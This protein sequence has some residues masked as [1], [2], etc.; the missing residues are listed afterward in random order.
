MINELIEIKEPE[1]YFSGVG[2]NKLP[3][4]SR[5]LFF[6]RTQ[7]ESLQQNDLKNRS[8]HRSLLCFNYETEGYV[9][10][11][12][13]SHSLKPGQALVILPYQFHHYSQLSSLKLKWL[14]CSFELEEKN[15]L[16]PLRNQ[17]ITPSEKS[18]TALD[19]LLTEWYSAPNPMRPAQVQCALLRLL[20]CLRQDGKTTP[21]PQHPVSG[22]SLIRTIN[23]HLEESQGQSIT[24]SDLARSTGYSDSRLRVLFK[25]AAGI[26]LGAYLQNYRINR[27]I[28]LLRTTNIPIADVAEAA[29]FGSPQAFS[30]IFKQTTD[31]S[32]RA[33]RSIATKAP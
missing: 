12:H 29:G 5:V 17:V 2:T 14:F 16:E 28:A 22:N 13:Y 25:E 20:L 3:M 32:P 4:P 9:H 26:P 10:L 8:H 15:F 30:R 19:S 11:D 7:K 33:Y 6:L 27:A 1:D 21:Q 24:V 18:R 23:L 31:L